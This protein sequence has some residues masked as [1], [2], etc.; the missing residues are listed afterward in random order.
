VEVRVPSALG[1]GIAEELQRA[2]DTRVAERLREG[3]AT[4]WGPPG[5]PEI[6]D[7]LGWLS[8]AGGCSSASIS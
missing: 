3:D 4:L 8:E 2:A 7:R 6:A 5:A 1:P